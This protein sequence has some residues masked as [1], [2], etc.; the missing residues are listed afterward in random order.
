MS[1]KNNNLGDIGR[2]VNIKS[3]GNKMKQGINL[4]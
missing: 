1:N 3:Y 4:I 2:T